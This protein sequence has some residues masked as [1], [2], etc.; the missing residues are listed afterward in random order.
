MIQRALANLVVRTARAIIR[1]AGGETER[2]GC[3]T[4]SHALRSRRERYYSQCSRCLKQLRWALYNQRQG[5]CGICHRSLARPGNWTPW[6]IDHIYPKTL[7][8]T[9]D[10]ANLQLVHRGCNKRKGNTVVG[11]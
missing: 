11:E 2:L 4:C 10:E 7:G 1:L 9:D 5:K 6:N 3:V 8:G